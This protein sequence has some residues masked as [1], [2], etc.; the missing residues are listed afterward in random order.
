LYLATPSQWL[1]NR[2]LTSVLRGAVRDWKVIPNGIDLSVFRPGPKSAARQELGLPQNVWISLFV[3]FTLRNNRFKDYATIK[4]VITQVSAKSGRPHYL[5]C[6][7]EAGE[8]QR[9]GSAVIRFIDYQPNRNKLAR[10][11]QAADVY[12][13]ASHADNFPT[14]V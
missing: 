12:L 2:A 8:E 11:Y 5:V 1:M 3:G 14:V 10:Y 7:G 6:V 9:C 4:S 13:Q